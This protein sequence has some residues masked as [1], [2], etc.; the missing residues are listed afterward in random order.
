MTSKFQVLI[1]QSRFDRLQSLSGGLQGQTIGGYPIVKTVR[2][3]RG[4][5]GQSRLTVEGPINGRHDFLDKL[6][7][8]QHNLEYQVK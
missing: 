3:P 8:W 4:A 5:V 6:I 2:S 1:P 7:Q